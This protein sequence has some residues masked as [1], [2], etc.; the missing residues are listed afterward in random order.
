MKVEKINLTKSAGF[1]LKHLFYKTL[2]EHTRNRLNP[3]G[4]LKFWSVIQDNQ[5]KKISM[6]NGD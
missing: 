4:I 3:D 2:L 6:D 5:K 1:F